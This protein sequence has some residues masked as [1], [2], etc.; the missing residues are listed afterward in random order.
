LT[1]ADLPNRDRKVDDPPS[2]QKILGVTEADRFHLLIDEGYR[3]FREFGCG[4]GPETRHGLF[5]VDREGTI[6]SQ[7]VG[8]TPFSDSAEVFDRLRLIVGRARENAGRP[9]EIGAN[10]T[11][12]P[13]ATVGA[14]PSRELTPAGGG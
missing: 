11:T 6:R 12:T 14:A 4:S 3:A 1:H 7:Y 2:A 10:P 9:E 5:L 13:G 8:E